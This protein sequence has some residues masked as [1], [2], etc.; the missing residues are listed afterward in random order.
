MELKKSEFYNKATQMLSDY[1]SQGGNVENLVA[2]DKLYQLI[3]NAK[4]YDK[5]GKR[6]DLETKFSLLGYP[7][8]GK[9]VVPAKENLINSIDEY[10][11]NG[12]SFH[13]TRKNLPFFEKLNSY[14]RNLRRKGLVV[15]HEQLMKDLGYKQYSDTFFK[16]KKLFN[17]KN[18][19]DE[20]NFVDDYKK[21]PTMKS[22]VEELALQYNIPTYLI[23]TLLCDEQLKKV[24]IS[25]D[26]V[27]VVEK[28][29]KEYV[30]KHGTLKNIKRNDSSLYERFNTLIKYYSDGSEARFTKA[31][32]LEIFGLGDVDNGFKNNIPKDIEID[33]IMFNLKEKYGTETILIKNINSKDYYKIVRK[34]VVMGISIAEL[35]KTYGLVCNGIYMDRLSK[36][37][38]R[39]IPYYNE[40]KTMRDDI[41]KKSGITV[42]NGYCEEEAFEQKLLA[43][44]QAYALYKDKIE[45]ALT[46]NEIAT[47]NI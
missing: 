35:F 44:Q 40:M 32:W 24:A 29:L 42:N 14:A 5:D 38:M 22:Y 17:L 33:E 41:I 30:A 6:V 18:Y 9:V 26:Y 34:S 28:Q 7:R 20:N 1:V 23:V 8:K 43:C 12:G 16:C 46:E 15:N 36:V 19:R 47:N 2:S 39:E 37:Y 4:I 25:V 3:K 21:N 31:E 45:N 10:L 27:S 11:K 13:I